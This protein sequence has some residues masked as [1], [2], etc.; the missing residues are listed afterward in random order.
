MLETTRHVVSSGRDSQ[1][2]KCF[3]LFF[4]HPVDQSWQRT[5]FTPENL[6]HS[7]NQLLAVSFAKRPIS[8]AK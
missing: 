8:N 5:E 4:S 2:S 1:T 6:Q 3:L 7:A